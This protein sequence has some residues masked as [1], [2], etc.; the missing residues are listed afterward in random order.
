MKI[1]LFALLLL[2]SLGLSSCATYYQKLAEFNT[3]FETGNLDK[4]ESVLAKD[5]KAAEGRNRLLHFMNLGTVEMLR[6]NYEQSNLYFNKADIAIEDYQKNPAAQALT[7]VSNPMLQEYRAEDFEKVM[8]HYYKSINYLQLNNYEAAMVECRRL[9]LKLNQLNDKYTK[10]NRYSEDAFGLTLMGIIYDASG[11]ANNAFIA[12]R[13]ALNTYDKVYKEQFNTEAPLQLKKD[14]IRT[15]Y[16]SGFREEAEFYENKFGIKVNTSTLQQPQ[17]VFFWNNG[18]GPI[19]AENSINFSIIKGEGGFVNFTNDELGIS[20]P[21]P[22]SNDGQST[23][24]ALGDLEFVRVAF[25]KYVE[26]P[27]LYNYA[28]LDNGQ[29]QFPLEKAEDINSIAFKT[30]ND[31]MLREMGTSLLRLATKKAAEYAARDQ[32]QDL[33]SV[34]GMVN[35]FTEKADTRN[36]QTLPHSISYTRVDLRE[37]EQEIVLR[38]KSAADMKLVSEQKF[39]FV[40]V[41]GKTIF[42]VYQNF[43]SQ[44][45]TPIGN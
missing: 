40:G 10:K 28:E 32:N 11:D 29:V 41:N 25:P 3:Q 20:F 8:I 7:L 12:Y 38:T 19:K 23:G 43:E 13:N 21:F 2:F 26:R 16:Q 24:S 4:A 9:N 22:V 37:G 27:P 39:S 14:L 18:L 36:W 33:G 5:K 6:G 15:A 35:A 30:L 31:R 45:I 42:Q 34:I 17:L 44:L 1:S